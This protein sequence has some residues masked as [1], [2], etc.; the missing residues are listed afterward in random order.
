[1][2]IWNEY[3]DDED[4][5]KVK[6]I[7]DA[8]NRVIDGLLILADTKYV[9]TVLQSSP[10]IARRYYSFTRDFDGLEKLSSNFENMRN[11]LF[12]DNLDWKAI[13]KTLEQEE[14]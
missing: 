10:A 9:N 7:L 11:V 8:F 3:T 14:K 2:E 6:E 13:S 4:R 5:E 12:G 1:M